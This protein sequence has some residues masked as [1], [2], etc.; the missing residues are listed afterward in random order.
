VSSRLLHIASTSG[1]SA[2]QACEAVAAELGQPGSPEL[3][4]QGLAQLQAWRTQ[5]VLWDS[6]DSEI[7]HA[8]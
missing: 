8:P 6:L 7:R 2:R 4:T 5:G 1:L 3:V